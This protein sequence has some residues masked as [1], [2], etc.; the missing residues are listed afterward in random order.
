MAGWFVVVLAPVWPLANHMS[1]YYLTVPGIGLAWL[2]SGALVSAWRAGLAARMLGIA[3][4][5]MY[6]AGSIA[7]VDRIA[8]RQVDVT[9]RMRVLMRALEDTSAY[10]GAAL[11]LTG[12]P[13]D[14]FL[15][16]FHDNP[17]RL[18]GIDEAW[19]APGQDQI[20]DGAAAVDRDRYRTSIDRL[21]PRLAR[22]EVRV[23]ET[24][25]PTVRDVTG[26]YT[27]VARALFQETHHNFVDVGDPIYASNLWQGGPGWYGIENDARWI[28][29]GAGLDMWRDSD[30]P[31]RLYVTGYAPAAALASGPVKMRFLAG[32]Q[33]LGFAT[34]THPDQPFSADFAVPPGPAGTAVHIAMDCSRTFRAPGDSRDLCLVLKTFAIR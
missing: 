10:P 22:G 3:L 14:L 9:A 31:S 11:V 1:D 7:E 25:G 20:L 16:G 8:A 19:L 27:A 24:L 12:V 33:V 29:G 23:L 21:A 17:F 2:A 15:A 13:R 6:V 30:G 26:P 34:V 32:G 5:G 4:A 28:A 18:L